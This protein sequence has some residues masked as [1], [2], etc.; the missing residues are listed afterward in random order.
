MA[1][2]KQIKKKSPGPSFYFEPTL[3]ALDMLGGSGSMKKSI[4]K[5]YY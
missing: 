1:K 4:I 3:K 5:S 2:K